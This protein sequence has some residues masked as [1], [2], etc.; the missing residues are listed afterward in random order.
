MRGLATQIKAEQGPEIQQLQE[1]LNQWGNPPM[2][3]M[4]SG[5]SDMPGMVSDEEVTVL[6]N[7]EGVDASRFLLTQ[8]TAHHEGAIATAQTEVED[9]ADRRR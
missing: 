3:S 7:A 8:M 2:P 6:K 4:P 1:W 9:G 5:T